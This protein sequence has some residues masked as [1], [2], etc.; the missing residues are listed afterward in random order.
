MKNQTV[1]R[2]ISISKDDQGKQYTIVANVDHL[3]QED[4]EFYALSDMVVKIQA[5]ARNFISGKSTKLP[6]WLTFDKSSLTFTA[7]IEPKGSRSVSEATVDKAATL[8]T[9][10]DLA[11][12]MKMLKG[13][14]PTLND[15][16]LLAMI[17]K[18]VLVANGLENES[19]V[20]TNTESN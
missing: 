8:F 6:S 7:K 15:E 3:S 18:D 1:K 16:Q 20:D 14:F 9:N 13:M 4:I 17:P 12:K 19:E 10:L 2:T 11:G 5:P